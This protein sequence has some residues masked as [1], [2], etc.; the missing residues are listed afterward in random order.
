MY[1]GV[2]GSKIPRIINQSELLIL[3]RNGTYVRAQLNEIVAKTATD[4]FAAYN[5]A[6]QQ[7]LAQFLSE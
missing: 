3:A 2:P 4:N 1:A 5:S 7:F 6:S